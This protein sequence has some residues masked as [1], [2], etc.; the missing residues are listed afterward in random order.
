MACTDHPGQALIGG[1][2]GMPFALTGVIGFPSNADGGG[3]TGRLA[4][5]LAGWPGSWCS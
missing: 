5:S 4:N 2:H 3:K 1:G